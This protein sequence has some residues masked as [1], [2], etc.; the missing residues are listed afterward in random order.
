[1][2]RQV[3][4]LAIVFVAKDSPD[5]AAAEHSS[6]PKCLLTPWLDIDESDCAEL[7]AFGV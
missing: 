1:V 6:S 5:V 3:A 7:R 4:E 2:T